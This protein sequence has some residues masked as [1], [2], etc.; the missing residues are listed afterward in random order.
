MTMDDL[1]KEYENFIPNQLLK[2]FKKHATDKNLTQAQAKEVLENLKDRYDYAKIH[3]G[4]AIG[5]VTAE[6][7]GE[8]GTQMTLRVK[9]FAGVAE[10]NVT[11]GL[12][13]LIEIF[14]ARKNPSTP[15]SEI[16]IK[17][18]HNKD[19]KK[20]RKIAATIKE[21][22]LEEIVSEFSMNIAKQQ[23]EAVMNKSKLREISITIEEVVKILKAHL[24]NI[25]TRAYSDKITFKLKDQDSNLMDLYKLKEKLKSSYIKGVKG[26]TQVLPVKKDSEYVVITAGSNLKDI[27]V[28]KEVD[29]T[30]TTTN[31]IFQIEKVLGIEAAR[32]AIINEATGVISDQGLEIDARHILFISDIM[33][34]TGKIKGI[35]RSGITSEKESVLAR[36]SFETPIVHI[37][38]ASITGETDPLN[39]VVENVIVN[40]PVPLGTGLPDLVA[41]MKTPEK[42]KKKT[43]KA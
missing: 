9:H 33:T 18:P 39:S 38:N 29:E 2:E 13:R 20:V 5:I 40:Q 42:P 24:K 3:P 25:E 22:L 31:D 8:P 15:S 11:L 32:Q 27:L 1:I 16:Y 36:A 35:T 19:P 14:D 10:V 6:S 41:K 21:T 26:I 4:E 37:V 23:I 43:K 34:S 17:A 28:M 30:R 12:P 7:F